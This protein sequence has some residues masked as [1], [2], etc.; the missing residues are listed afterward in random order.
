MKTDT[1]REAQLEKKFV[2]MVQRRGG[3]ARKFVSPNQR[4]VPD[5]IVIWPGGE[6]HFVELKTHNGKLSKLQEFEQ[7]K[8][9]E[10]GCTV[11]TLHGLTGVEGYLDAVDGLIFG[12][13]AA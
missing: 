9:A 8:L 11:F 3:L 1:L 13:A 5:R 6:V 4:G 2:N 12:K 10:R 7:K